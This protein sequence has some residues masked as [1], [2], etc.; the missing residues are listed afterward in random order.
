MMMMMMMMCLIN[1]KIKNTYPMLHKRELCNEITYLLSEL[2]PIS[3]K[4][5]KLSGPE[6][7]FQKL[8]AA[9]SKKLAFNYD[10]KKR[11][12]KLVAKFHSWNCLRF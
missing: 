5:R 1:H 10:F 3:R 8:L 11:K 4:S 12:G 2:G 7:P 6:K 9:Y